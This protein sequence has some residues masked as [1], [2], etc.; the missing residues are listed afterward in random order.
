MCWQSHSWL[1]CV[2][3]SIPPVD[4]QVN[5]E[6]QCVTTV[7]SGTINVRT[8]AGVG[9]IGYSAAGLSVS[10]VVTGVAP[11]V[12]STSTTTA[13]TIAGS[14][15]GTSL[16]PGRT[17]IPL[18][19]T[20][21]LI[22]SYCTGVEVVCHMNGTTSTGAPFTGKC[23]DGAQCFCE[24]RCVCWLSLSGAYAD[25]S[26]SCLLDPAVGVGYSILLNNQWV[27]LSA[28]IGYAAPT[29]TSARLMQASSNNTVLSVIGTGFGS[30]GCV[31]LVPS[32]CSVRVLLFNTSVSISFDTASH[33]FTGGSNVTQPCSVGTWTDSAINCT[34][35]LSKTSNIPMYAS[36]TVGGQSATVVLP[37]AP[38]VITGV[39]SGQYPPTAGGTAFTVSGSGFGPPQSPIAVLVG[40]PSHP[41]LVTVVSHNDSA[42]T[43]LAPEGSGAGVGVQVFGLFTSS[44]VMPILSYGPPVVLGTIAFE[45]KPCSGSYPLQVFGQVSLLS[46]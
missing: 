1:P 37:F 3:N 25:S 38:V 14:R 2:L 8:P 15:F 36:V 12:W 17:S 30:A 9:S 11:Y 18:C 13:V 21:S 43:A 23:S 29:L 5:T 34:L 46:S 41:V 10:A 42:I 40:G 4:V 45:G 7:S 33:M 24:L 20:S 31:G 16:S 27:P 39:F 22:T 26:V 6:L 19:L 35:D 28:G 32:Q 44:A